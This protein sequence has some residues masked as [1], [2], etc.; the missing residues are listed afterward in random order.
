MPACFN[1]S[2][3]INVLLIFQLTGFLFVATAQ[4]DGM[5]KL[6]KKAEQ[7]VNDTVKAKAQYYLS[8]KLI[9]HG[10]LQKATVWAEKAAVLSRKLGFS[11]GIAWS[12]HILAVIKQ[13]QGDYPASLKYAFEALKVRE[14]MK[15]RS[16]IAD[17][18]IT[19][20]N[21]YSFQKNYKESLRFYTI[22]SEMAEEVGDKRGVATCYL[23]M[24]IVHRL[25]REYDKALQYQVKA[26][27]IRQDIK[28][29]IGAAHIN[30][31]IAN[32]YMETGRLKESLEKHLAVLKFAEAHDDKE[33]VVISYG[34]IGSV[35]YLMKNA[36]KAVYFLRKAVEKGKEMGLKAP[37]TNDYGVLASAD[38]LAGDFKAALEDYKMHV[39]YRDSLINEENTKKV[40]QQQMQYE[41]DKK[42]V[43][44]KAAQEKKDALAA[45]QLKQRKQERNFVIGG[46]VLVVI[47]AAIVFFSFIQKRKANKLLEEKNHLIENQKHL[48]EEKQKEILDSIHYAKRIQQTLMTSEF[49][50]DK[51]LRALN[52]RNV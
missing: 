2:R 48:V 26:L 50:I 28:D 25:L 9:E 45:E 10:E 43:E 31:A 41:F 6:L 37:L 36:G 32:I 13:D 7:A 42:E 34:N 5:N 12:L 24:G 18:Y 47:V 29:E 15:D 49:Y 14:Q 39:L 3:F 51:K 19:I 17:S 22:A 30:T 21:I 11:K 33:S 1:I 40:V 23:N 46:F 4:D 16:G 38:S 44:T 52:R 35:Y 8:W 20:G 27:E